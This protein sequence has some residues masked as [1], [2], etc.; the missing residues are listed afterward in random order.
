MA[1]AKD[2]TPSRVVVPRKL[3][4]SLLKLQVDEDISWEEAC[5]RATSLLAQQKKTIDRA[6]AREANR[7]YKSR[8][9]KEMNKARK[10]I[11]DQGYRAGYNRAM[12]IEHF[13]VPCSQC[14]KPMLFS[15]AQKDWG[16][17]VQSTLQQAFGRRV[18]V[19]C[20]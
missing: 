16:K 18:H 5:L 19:K 9:L 2:K 10:T 15:Q 20:P 14:G 8:H 7:R 11:F 1:S 12:T 3:K 17:H 4:M 13:T 6:V